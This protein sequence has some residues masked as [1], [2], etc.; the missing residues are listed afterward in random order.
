MSVLA[1]SLLLNEA[2][3]N[4]VKHGFNGCE[5]GTVSIRLDQDSA[6]RYALTIKDDGNGL[7]PEAT[8]LEGLGS[9]IMRSLAAQL[10]GE[11]TF[12]AKGGMMTR[13]VFPANA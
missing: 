8:E 6:E 7:A 1:L 11:I 10:R 13:V 3:T 4:S 9:N 5:R 2:I 12:V